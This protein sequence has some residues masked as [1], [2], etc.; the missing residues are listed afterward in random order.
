M[1]IALVADHHPLQAH[2]GLP[3]RQPVAQALALPALLSH[4]QPLA[5]S[6]HLR[7]GDIIISL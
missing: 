1:L 2:C 4:D 7:C 5:G 6:A 3:S